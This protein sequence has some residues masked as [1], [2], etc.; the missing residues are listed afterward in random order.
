MKKLSKRQQ[1]SSAALK[2]EGDYLLIGICT[3]TAATLLLYMLRTDL[4]SLSPLAGAVSIAALAIIISP[5]AMKVIRI[6]KENNQPKG[7]FSLKTQSWAFVLGDTLAV[8]TLLGFAVF[9][10]MHFE[11]GWYDSAWWIFLSIGLGVA[12]SLGFR[13]IDS[14]RYEKGDYERFFGHTKLWHDFPVYATLVSLSAGAGIPVVASW[15]S[16]IIKAGAFQVGSGLWVAVAAVSW[17]LL[18]LIDLLLIKPDP[19]NQHPSPGWLS[20]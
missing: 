20:N 12:A 6:K 11:K 13:V 18:A 10:W 5:V 1:A 4:P 2:R 15:C 17:L 14:P 19:V 8:P 16:D 7:M 3:A 9:Q